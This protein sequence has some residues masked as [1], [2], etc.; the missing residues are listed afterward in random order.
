MAHVGHPVL[1]CSATGHGLCLGPRLLYVRARQ[2]NALIERA[3][4]R[5]VRQRGSHRLY[6]VRSG[7]VVAITVVP[8][9]GGDIPVGTLKAIGRD[10]AAVLREG[11]LG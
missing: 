7:D 10:L 9:H 3:G 1:W 11:R 5:V 6:E 8:Q 2:V 4:G